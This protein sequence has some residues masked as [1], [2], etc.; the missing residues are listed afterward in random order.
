MVSRFRPG[1][2]VFR[3]GKSGWHKKLSLG[4]GQEIQRLNRLRARR[5]LPPMSL[6]LEVCCSPFW[7][8]IRTAFHNRCARSIST[9]REDHSYNVSS[10][11]RQPISWQE[12]DWLATQMLSAP[13]VSRTDISSERQ[14]NYATSR[15]PCERKST[16]DPVPWSRPGSCDW[17]REWLYKMMSG[18]ET[19]PV[20][21]GQKV[22]WS[23]GNAM[24]WCS[25]KAHWSW[26][27]V[28]VVLSATLKTFLPWAMWGHWS[29]KKNVLPEARVPGSVLNVFIWAW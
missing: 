20:L 1:K 27:N 4:T 24:W 10:I 14:V 7:S 3:P 18:S 16:A 5:R 11:S 9:V 6:P 8:M 28:M 21:P 29:H 19:R 17:Q 25:R 22:H 15:S 12:S 26:G 2:S 13:Q 23:W